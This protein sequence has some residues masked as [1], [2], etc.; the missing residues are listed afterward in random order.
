[1][2]LHNDLSPLAIPQMGVEN[3]YVL[4]FSTIQSGTTNQ[5]RLFTNHL[6]SLSLTIIGVYISPC[7]Q[8]NVDV[9]R[10]IIDHHLHNDIIF[11]C[12]R[13]N[14]IHSQKNPLE[15]RLPSQSDSRIEI[16]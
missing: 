7:V 12:L 2:T 3:Y 9:I 5:K 14:K 8:F 4:R 11:S 13:Q 10:N 16:C 15:R 1:M 6:T